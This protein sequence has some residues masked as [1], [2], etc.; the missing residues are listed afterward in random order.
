[1]TNIE[2]VTVMKFRNTQLRYGA[3]SKSLHW[4]VALLIL[5]LAWLGWYM[6]GLDYYD[7]WY[8]DALNSHKAL[9][10][11]ALILA[12]GKVLW[13]LYSRPPPLSQT[14]GGWERTLARITHM[15]LFAMMVLIPVTGYLISTAEG[16]PVSVFGWF[17]IPAVAPQSDALT[18]AAIELHYYFAYGTV[19]LAGLHALA[20]IKHQL[21]DRDGSLT[22]M[23]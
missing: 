18:D 16:N 14:L 15:T 4:L 7:R 21:V 12:V 2:S 19:I 20:A 6:L 22:K 23:V 1:M 13:S 3:V 5:G 10:M 9:G 8:Y 11:L 17:E